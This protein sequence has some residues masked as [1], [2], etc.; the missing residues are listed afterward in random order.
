MNPLRW[1]K[2]F[3]LILLVGVIVAVVA[4]MEQKNPDLALTTPGA[5]EPVALYAETAQERMQGQNQCPLGWI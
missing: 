1:T 3:T 2:L 4:A 5:I